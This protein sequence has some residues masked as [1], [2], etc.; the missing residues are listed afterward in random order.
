MSLTGK[1]GIILFGNVL[2][3]LIRLALPIILTRIMDQHDY[4][5]YRQVLLIHFT[6]IAVF[7]IGI[8]HSI[9]YFLPQLAGNKQ[10]NFVFQSLAILFLVGLVLA[11]TVWLLSGYIA[12]SFSSPILDIY[13]KIF[14]VYIVYML[15][16]Q[17]F[18]PIMICLDKHKLVTIQ[19]LIFELIFSLSVLIPLFGGYGLGVVFWVLAISAPIQFLIIGYF[20]IRAFADKAIPTKPLLLKEQ[21]QYSLPIGLN[22]AL[23]ILMKEIDKYMISS[24]FRPSEFAVYSLG[25]REIPFVYTIALSVSQVIQPKLVEH[26]SKNEVGEFVSLWH[27]SIRKTALIMYPIFVFFFIFAEE[28]YIF[29]YTEVYVQSA[30]VFQIYLLNLPFRITSYGSFLLAMGKTHDVVISSLISA[31]CNIFFNLLLIKTIGFMGA[32]VA[33][34]LVAYIN[35]GYLLFRIKANLQT[36]W[37]QLFPWLILLKIMGV[38]VFAGIPIYFFK[39]VGMPLFLMLLMGGIFY[40]VFYLVAA[41]RFN[42]IQ[43][44][45][46]KQLIDYIKRKLPK[47]RT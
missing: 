26:Y 7:P 14:S 39:L 12:G 31:I 16:I 18:A 2:Q 47:I 43:M 40:G 13:L 27:R 22:G 28:F 42:I 4:G 30:L 38:A 17:C 24:M 1:T 29:F 44:A 6:I 36:S 33:T 25:A 34:I 8:P 11:G 9:F 32:A 3:S 20:M 45:E 19:K 10:K 37:S 23:G 5:T 41:L 21:F 15:P 46:I 35:T